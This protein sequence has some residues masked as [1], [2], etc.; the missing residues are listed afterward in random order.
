MVV[1]THARFTTTVAGSLYGIIRA[2]VPVVVERSV[3]RGA[4]VVKRWTRRAL[5]AAWTSP[6]P[7]DI[8]MS[9]R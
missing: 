5:R 3:A 2:F 4:V 7:L 8:Y 6:S 9:A 1:A